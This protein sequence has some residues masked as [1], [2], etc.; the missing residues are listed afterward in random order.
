MS[1]PVCKIHSCCISYKHKL[2][3]KDV[4]LR[5]GHRIVSVTASAR[6]TVVCDSDTREQEAGRDCREV[7]MSS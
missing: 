6:I 3:F 5:L 4:I 7:A 2:K 1:V